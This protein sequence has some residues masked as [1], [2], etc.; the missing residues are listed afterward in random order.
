MIPR[1][2]ITDAELQVIADIRAALAGTG[3]EPFHFGE[4]KENEVYLEIR[5]RGGLA[6]AKHSFSSRL[7]LILRP[8][9]PKPNPCPF[10]RTPLTYGYDVTWHWFKC[11]HCGLAT[12]NAASQTAAIEAANRLSYRKEPT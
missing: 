5:G 7:Y 2:S 11:L 8:L 6:T 10:C 9:P 4:V 1:E 3:H 12:P